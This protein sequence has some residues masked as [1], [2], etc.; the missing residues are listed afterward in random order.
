MPAPSIIRNS[1]PSPQPVYK[2]ITGVNT[3]RFDDAFINQL[4]DLLQVPASE[5]QVMRIS[6]MLG[7]F[8]AIL[9][10]VI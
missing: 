9:Y 6:G 4:C 3:D 5:G 7:R 1:V 2:V 10:I 8:A